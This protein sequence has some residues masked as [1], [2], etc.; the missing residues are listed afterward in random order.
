MDILNNSIKDI[1]I[2]Y[3]IVMIFKSVLYIYNRI[4]IG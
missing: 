2:Y 4:T 3:P 1:S